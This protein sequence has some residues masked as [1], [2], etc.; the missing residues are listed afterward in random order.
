VASG[1]ALDATLVPEGFEDLSLEGA[2]PRHVQVKSRV[3]HLGSFP[4]GLAS[5]H[6]L[7]AWDRHASRD[8]TDEHLVVVFERGVEGE[9][10]LR[11]F[12]C[13]LEDALAPESALREA[14]RDRARRQGMSKGDLVRAMSS[15]TVVTAS[16]DTLTAETSRN[17]AAL[18]DLTPSGLL[19]AV[20]DLRRMV[21]EAADANAT[22]DF[23]RRASLDRTKLVA[24]IQRFAEHVDLDS[25][26]LAVREVCE[27]LDI[28]D[29]A[30]P[31]DRFYQGVAVRPAHVAAG[32]VVPR[33]DLVA[34]V[35]AGLQHQRAAVLTG[36]SGVGKSAVLW[37]VPQALPGVLWFRVRRLTDAD[38]PALIRLA[39]A[40]RAAPDAPVGFLIDAAGTGDFRGWARLRAE[41][42]SLL[43]VLLLATARREDLMALGDLSECAT[44]GVQLDEDAAETI[45]KGLVRR[46]ATTLPYWRES[47][48]KAH[49]LTLEF[50]YLLTQ[51]RRLQQVIDEQVRRRIDEDRWAEL[52]LIGLVAVAD[53][54]SGSIPLD[55]ARKECGSTDLELRQAISRLAD[56]HLIV[57]RDGVLT[58]LHTVRSAAI[59][60]AIHTQPPP[61][62]A[63]TV[64]AVLRSLPASQ[65]HRFIANALR[66]QPTLAAQV[67]ATAADDQLDIDRTVGYLH[68]LRLAD[69]YAVA[70]AWRDI[71]DA[72]KVP[73][74]TQPL[75][76]MA[77]THDLDFAG[78]LPSEFEAARLAML[79]VSSTSHLDD[80][81]ERLTF[82][83]IAEL[84]GATADTRA[85]ARLL[86]TLRN[87]GAGLAA[88]AEPLLSR[89]APLVGALATCPVEELGECMAA[90]NACGHDMAVLLQDRIGGEAET[91]RRLR[92][93]DPWIT[94]LD[95]RS[96]DGD[97]VGYGRLLHASDELQGNPRDRAVSLGRI[98]LRCL[99]RLGRVDVQALL[100]GGYELSIG[101]YT[102]GVSGLLRRYD[103]TALDTS[104]NQA[105]IRAAHTLL[106]Q[107]DTERLAA[108]LPMLGEADELTRMIGTALVAPS[109]SGSDAPAF[110]QRVEGLDVC[111]RALKPSLGA[112][113]VGDTA[114]AEERGIPRGDDLSALVTDLTGNVYARLGRP[115]T[116][117]A[118]A[119]YLSDTVIAKHLQ[120]AYREPW[121]LL[122]IGPHPTPL[123]ELAKALSDLHAVVDELSRDDADRD[124]IIRSARSGTRKGALARAADTCRRARK[125][126]A[127][128]RARQIEAAC[129]AIGFP[130]AV[131]TPRAHQ[132]AG[133]EVA[134]TVN[135]P[136]LLQ[137]SQAVA[138]LETALAGRQ[139]DETF[140]II[141]LRDGRPVP[142]LVVKLITNT[143]PSPGVEPWQQVL[144][145]PHPTVLTDAFDRAHS[146]LETLSGTTTLP[147]AQR[148][149]ED[150]LGAT[151]FA[152]SQFRSERAE[153]TALPR[154]PVID[155]L[156]AILDGHAERIQTELEN[157]ASG[158]TLAEDV[159][160]GALQGSA[161]ETFN[162]MLGARIL[163]LEW[164]IDSSRA[165]ELLAT[166]DPNG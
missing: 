136:S 160:A 93:H 59:A 57:E 32:L 115:D 118:L 74:S 14:L 64:A 145:T 152:A 5:R 13:V 153:I 107:S 56:E 134:I 3:D 54:W 112:V 113:E 147:G 19:Y 45:F 34:E 75:L 36:P 60:T 46:G 9:A 146:A 108:A 96:P 110:A 164:D 87:H 138:A 98:L 41:A 149:H 48:E 11:A 90:A 83:R 76:F 128:R 10:N 79:G 58:G 156:V 97:T 12:D 82:R 163:A 120:G 44:I 94:E 4:V 35:L 31:D 21:A 142:T 99:P 119:A 130:V 103:A 28:A 95:V 123:D 20:R 7:D 124:K 37:T 150:V 63:D 91:L 68:G 51:G 106:A 88:A 89:G 129:Q 30:A 1:E 84:L 81:V 116:Y 61:T 50:T 92:D 144:N 117:R 159:A 131:W 125:K 105:R 139:P 67:T 161:T 26:E 114:L 77:A 165:V 24:A 121:H 141:P 100:A 148:K 140:R 72:H 137:W 23:P 62:L 27:P 25:L 43:G 126:R 8:S 65:L 53:Q 154:D 40:Y 70:R 85:A 78:L 39:R 66:H 55:T 158:P 143:W 155:E 47:Y 133:N 132:D 151:E 2:F 101:D 127:Q 104:W 122:G 52:N 6:I 69:F 49:G 29:P 166:V 157:S 73:A 80:L 22:A 18:I 162:T 86:S 42:A 135:L 16:W 15:T 38:V 71:A 109:T 17:L 33:P 102:H 111:A